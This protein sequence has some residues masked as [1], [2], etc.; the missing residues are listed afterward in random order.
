MHRTGTKHIV[1]HMQKNLSYSGPSYPSSPVRTRIEVVKYKMTF[2]A[3]SQVDIKKL[4]VIFISQEALPKV[5]HVNEPSLIPLS[6]P[7][8]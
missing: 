2:M 6:S 4:K 1:R 5:D 8:S 7:A 3:T